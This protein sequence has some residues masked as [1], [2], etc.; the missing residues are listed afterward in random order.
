MDETTT[1]VFHGVTVEATITR[2]PR[3]EEFRIMYATLVV[4]LFVL[5][6]TLCWSF[7]KDMGYFDKSRSNSDRTPE[8]HPQQSEVIY[9]TI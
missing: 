2:C 8:E 7:L 4:L 5:I 6:V 9:K 1:S 3:E